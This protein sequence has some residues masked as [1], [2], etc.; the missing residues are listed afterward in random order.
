MV[1]VHASA[2]QKY[3]FSVFLYSRK[4]LLGIAIY[5][6]IEGVLYAQKNV[7]GWFLADSKIDK[8]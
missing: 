4:I 5:L 7:P 6:L 8:C 1:H 3:P 2:L